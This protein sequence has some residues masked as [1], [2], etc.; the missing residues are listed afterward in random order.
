MSRETIPPNNIDAEMAL[1]GLCLFDADAAKAALPMLRPQDFY[2]HVHQPIFEAI[3]ALENAGKPHDKI[4]VA[5]HL[6]AQHQL[7]RVGGISYLSSLMTAAYEAGL[8]ANNAAYYARVIAEKAVLYRL[9]LAAEKIKVAA[10]EGEIDPIGAIADA[11]KAV[12]EASDGFAPMRSGGMLGDLLVQ[13]WRDIDRAA[14]GGIQSQKTPWPT[15]D[16]MVGGWFGGEMVV[17]FGRPKDGKSSAIAQLMQHVALENGLVV[18]FALEMSNQSVIRRLVANR[19]HIQ[20][21][22]LRSGQLYPSDWD[23]ISASMGELH[24]LPVY[25]CDSAR[26]VSEMRRTVLALQAKQP[27]RAVIVDHVGFV[28]DTEGPRNETENDR[29]N[30][31]YK[32]L[33]ALAKELDCVMHVVQHAN[34]AAYD[35]EPTLKDIRGGGNA[36]GHAHTVIAPYRPDV[37]RAPEDGKFLVLANRE[38][39]TGAVPM[40]FDAPRNCWTEIGTQMEIA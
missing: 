7:D 40:R 19:A 10:L 22:R 34:R 21:R 5:E 25:L 35:R 17:W 39:M 13:T 38:G 15:L 11:E 8:S 31:I 20:A 14:S 28:S 36:E 27:V 33:L 23:R 12:R 6:R 32:R 1:L 24:D 3:A 16:A 30:R 26:T 37:D 9:L 18:L 29:L 2:A 4:A